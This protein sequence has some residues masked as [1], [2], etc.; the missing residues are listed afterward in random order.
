MKK[1]Y[2]V[3]EVEIVE[4][5]DDLMDV[6]GMSGRIAGIDKQQ[7][8]PLEHEVENEGGGDGFGYIPP[9]QGW[10]DGPDE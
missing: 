1:E 8:N 5:E 10:G 7:D 4:L 2:I 9:Y 6:F 3:P